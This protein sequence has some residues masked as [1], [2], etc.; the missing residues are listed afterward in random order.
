M[1][2]RLIANPTS[3]TDRALDLLPLIADRLRTRFADLDVTV[4]SGPADASR[5]AASA[6]TEQCSALFVAGGDGTLNAALRGLFERTDSPRLSVGIIPLGTGNDFAK[7]L[8]LGE[9]AEA[10]LDVL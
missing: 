10:A 7:A 5:A 1:R 3:G 9:D 4:T 8:D 6:V 2:A